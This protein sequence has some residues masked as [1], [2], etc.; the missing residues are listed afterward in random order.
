MR[1]YAK[2]GGKI[3]KPAYRTPSSFL[4]K[5]IFEKIRH[6]SRKIQKYLFKSEKWDQKKVRERSL[7]DTEEKR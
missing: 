5:K 4:G 7:A 3:G 6:Q 1:D 2:T